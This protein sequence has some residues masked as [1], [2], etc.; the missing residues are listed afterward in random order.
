M[1]KSATVISPSQV[2]GCSEDIKRR[3]N[4]YDTWQERCSASPGNIEL[5]TDK[6]HIATDLKGWGFQWFRTSPG[7]KQ[8]QDRDFVTRL[9]SIGDLKG[10]ESLCCFYL[11]VSIS[12]LYSISIIKRYKSGKGGL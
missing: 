7:K 11:L 6:V 8:E 10:A 9:S 1:D 2:H 5:Q 4:L 12:L 3:D